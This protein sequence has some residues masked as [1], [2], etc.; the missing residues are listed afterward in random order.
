V[1][2]DNNRRIPKAASIVF[3]LAIVMVFALTLTGA[4]RTNK[5]IFNSNQKARY[6]PED[7]VG[8]ASP[9]FNITINSASVA[10]NGAITGVVTLTDTAGLGLDIYGVTTPGVMALS[11]TMGYIPANA[12][13]YTSYVTSTSTG[14]AGTF[15]RP[16]SENTLTQSG[17]KLTAMGNGQYQYVFSNKA[18]ANFDQTATHTLAVWGSRTLTPFGL[19]N[20]FASAT[21]NFVPNGGKVTKIRDVVSTQA[22]DQ[23]H[24]QL[25]FHGGSRRGVQI[26]VMCHTPAMI[27]SGTGKSVDFKVYI[28]KIHMGS[29]LPSVQAGTPYAIGSSDW[30]TVVYPADVR[31]CETCHDPKTATQAN[32]YNTNPTAE[33][34]GAC[35]DDVN[36]ASGV[37]HA[38][39]PQPDNS[40]CAECHV[41]QG[42]LEFDASIKGAHTI[43]TDSSYLTGLVVNLNKV[44]NSLAGQKPTVAFTIQDKNGNGI[45]FPTGGTLSLTMAGPTTDYGN[46]SFGADVTTTPGYV[47]ESVTASACDNN[48]NCS[49][50]FTHGV[51]AGATGTYAIGVEARRTETVLPGTTSS[52]SVEY[53]A[54]NKVVY[55]SVDGSPVQPRREVVSINNCNRCH[56]ELSVH[57]TLRNQTEYCVMCHNPANSDFT[58]R[59]SATVAAQRTM[60]NQGIAFDLLVHRVHTGENLVSI[61][62][63]DYT[64]IGFGGSINDFSAAYGTAIKG[65]TPTGVRYPAFDPTGSPHDTAN[66]EMCHIGPNAIVKTL[67]GSTTPLTL[68][69]ETNLPLGKNAVTDPQGPINPDPA[70][71]AACTG[72]HAAISTASHAMANTTALGESCVACHGSSADY[73]TLG[74]DYSVN[75]VHAQY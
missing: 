72:C 33:A 32:L 69:T 29:S 16:S 58:Q 47:T 56:V 14:A 28:H 15:V 53:G 62:Q 6:A 54:I 70:I 52:Q 5:E 40:M 67:P 11:M 73:S 18:P 25:S 22:C 59:P 17:G 2:S 41:P 61:F 60:P 35:H 71:T 49:Y 21:Y 19:P 3:R 46:T 68:G 64:I 34:C 23:C 57:G 12:E 75:S 66:C 38:G 39:G 13:Q 7:V 31:R 55:F 48:G 50:A 4:G 26:C 8:L 45:A 51:P 20:E 65:I 63:R 24:D 27:D 43:P 9:G 10:A 37:N 42:E 30:S 1:T 74:L 44:T 36:F